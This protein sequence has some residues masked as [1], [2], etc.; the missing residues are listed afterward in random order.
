M[1]INGMKYLTDVFM[2]SNKGKPSIVT[3]NTSNT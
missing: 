2:I 1:S 3:K